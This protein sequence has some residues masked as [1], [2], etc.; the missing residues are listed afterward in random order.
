M[1]NHKKIESKGDLERL[2]TSVME[3]LGTFTRDSLI[4][5]SLKAAGKSYIA[6]TQN[7]TKISNCKIEEFLKKKKIKQK[8]NEYSFVEKNA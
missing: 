7:V 6:T 4:Y 1:E 5:T 2:I 8:G 3:E